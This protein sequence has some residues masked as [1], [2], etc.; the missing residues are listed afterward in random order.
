MIKNIHWSS[1]KVPVILVKSEQNLNFIYGFSKNTQTSHFM[2]IRPGGAELFR[3]DGRT[4]MTKLI[5]ALA[6]LKTLLKTVLDIRKG[7]PETDCA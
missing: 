7:R 5:V 3:E 1:C 6:I 2:K 4:D